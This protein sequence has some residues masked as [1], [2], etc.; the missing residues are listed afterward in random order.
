MVGVVRAHEQ[1]GRDDTCR[2]EASQE[3]DVPFMIWAGERGWSA[4]AEWVMAAVVLIV[5][6][7]GVLSFVYWKEANEGLDKDQRAERRTAKRHLR[8]VTKSHKTMIRQAEQAILAAENTHAASI[9]GAERALK[10]AERTHAKGIEEAQQRLDELQDPRGK[11]LASYRGHKLYEHAL[12]TPH[13]E[14]ILEGATASVDTVGNL[15]TKSRATLDRMA[16][17]GQEMGP[18]G[19]I[20]SNGLTETGDGGNNDLHLLVEAHGASSVVQCSPD[21]GPRARQ[22]AVQIMSAAAAE[23]V[24]VASLPG[25]LDIAHQQLQAARNATGPIDSAR[26]ELQRVRT[27]P[28]ALATIQ[29]AKEGLEQTRRDPDALGAI[30]AA[31]R[32][33][34][35]IDGGSSSTTGTAVGPP[36]PSA[37]PPAPGSTP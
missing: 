18:L 1:A 24:Y 10:K 25:L 11:R 15:I 17:D 20:L 27:D 29:L 6:A 31:A 9:R 16:S 7:A 21:D 5:V 35:A 26:S 14:A 28:V 13:G 36:P 8:Q 32:D 23:S 2:P 33:L 22:F 4:M 37:P 3:P 34:A 19:S 12:V 30:E